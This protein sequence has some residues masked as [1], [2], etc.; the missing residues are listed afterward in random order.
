MDEGTPS[1]AIREISIMKELSHENILRL[2]DVVHTENKLMMVFDYMDYDLKKYMDQEGEPSKGAETRKRFGL[3][4][5]V[6]KRFAYEMLC[7]IAYC[8]KNRVLHR[9]LK[10]QN[11]LINKQGVLKLGDFGLARAV[12]IPVNTFS[13]EVVTLWYRAPDVL[14]GSRTYDAAIDIWS[15][16]CIIAE[17]YTGRPLF[18]GTTNADQLNR[19]FHIMGTPT[20]ET[21]PGVSQ[22]PDYEASFAHKPMQKA[23]P[24]ESVVVQLREDRLS[25]DL[26]QRLLL[27][28]PQK[29]ISADEVIHAHAWFQEMRQSFPPPNR[30]GGHRGPGGSMDPNLPGMRLPHN[31]MVDPQEYGHY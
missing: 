15:A 29:R 21:W 31:P 23:K 13:N 16:G 18:P 9:D 10:P 14:L 7:G 19:I 24:L 8:H 26:L 20:E 27:P 4:P 6:V 3:K 28:C 17:M 25:L 5:A 11:L 30:G 1:T 12:G 22:Y 2:R